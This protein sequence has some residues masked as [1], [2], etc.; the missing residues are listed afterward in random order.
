MKKTPE[1]PIAVTKSKGHTLAIIA[2][3]PQFHVVDKPT[4]LGG[5]TSE[6]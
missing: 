3:S 4:P 5:S 1:V 2:V 6:V